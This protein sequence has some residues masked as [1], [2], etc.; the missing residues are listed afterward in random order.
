MTSNFIKLLL[1]V[2]IL[3]SFLGCSQKIEPP[4][5]KEKTRDFANVLYNRQLFHQ[6]VQQ[7]EYYLNNYKIDKSEQANINYTIGDIYFERIKDVSTLTK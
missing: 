5:S 4:I 3:T 2:I 1:I 7:Y 6:S